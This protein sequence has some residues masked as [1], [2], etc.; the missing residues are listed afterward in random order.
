MYRE[1]FFRK[2]RLKLLDNKTNVLH[3]YKN[4]TIGD[5]NIE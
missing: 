3:N 4:L 5:D 1:A 2:F